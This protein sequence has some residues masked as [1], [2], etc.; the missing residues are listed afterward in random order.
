MAYIPAPKTAALTPYDPIDG[1]YR[2]RLDANESFLLPTAAERQA[3]ADAA[4]GQ[5]L[6][7]YPDPLARGLCAA[8]AAYYGVRPETVT[9][10][11]GSDELISVIMSAFLQKGERVLTLAPDFSMYRFYTSI[12]ETPCVTLEKTAALLPDVD[13]IL[14]E[15]PRQ[16]IRMVIFSNPCNPTSLGLPASEVRRLID[17]TDALVVLDEAYMDFWDQTLLGEAADYDNLIILR[18][19]SKAVGLAALRAGFAVAN[20]RLTG[21][22]RAAKS[23]YNVNAVTQAMARVVL[24]DAAACRARRDR[25]V[26][27]RDE[28]M[29]GLKALEGAGALTRVYDS[30]TNF[31]FARMDGARRVFGALK[32]A[33]IIVRCFGDEYLRITAGAPEENAALL[34]MLGKILHNR[35]G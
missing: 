34:D 22:L 6:N 4:F 11:N 29:G 33:G 28:L 23:P 27:A 12:A 31:A 19:C 9:A 8:F 15:I 5:A 32:D 26:A 1:D 18:T 7:R 2:I 14:A 20:E 25:L 10:G 3:M 13:A 21:I 16:N 35:Q 24:S 17:G 30:R